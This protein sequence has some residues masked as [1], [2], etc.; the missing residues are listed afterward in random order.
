MVSTGSAEDPRRPARHRNDSL[1]GANIHAYACTHTHTNTH[2]NTF[3]QT[4]GKIAK[5]AVT[6]RA[7]VLL[8][9]SGAARVYINV[10]FRRRILQRF[11]QPLKTRRRRVYNVVFTRCFLTFDFP[12]VKFVALKHNETAASKAI[13]SNAER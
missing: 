9:K 12:R 13:L 8:E 5:T 10:V 4:G 2:T 7:K 11:S 6:T 3:T 1:F